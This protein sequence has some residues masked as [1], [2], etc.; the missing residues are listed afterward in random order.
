MESASKKKYRLTLL[1]LIKDL[2]K[3][4]IVG[5]VL[6]AIF[7]NVLFFVLARFPFNM[8]EFIGATLSGFVIGA[9]IGIILRCFRGDDMDDVE[10]VA[11]Y[12]VYAGIHNTFVFASFDMG[13]GAALSII[14]TILTILYLIYRLA[15]VALVFPL[16]FVY[17]CIM[18]IL[19][20]IFNG[21][22]EFI[23]NILDKLVP[24]VAMICGV[25]AVTVALVSMGGEY[26][27]ERV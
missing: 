23:G 10:G 4:T 12:N 9:C 1:Y 3:V 8:R 7:V 19:E 13:G 26:I 17:V 20:S 14:G 22:P 21:I 11:L 15:A 25:V 18:A 5:G 27:S 24:I 2:L 16:T 6:C